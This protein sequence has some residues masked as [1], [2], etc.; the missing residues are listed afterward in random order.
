M[1]TE[2]GI[3]HIHATADAT[4]WAAAGIIAT[5]QAFSSDFKLITSNVK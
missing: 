1:G 2:E 5:S 4:T 3:H